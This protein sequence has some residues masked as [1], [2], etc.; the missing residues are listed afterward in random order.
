M[1]GKT[2]CKVLLRKS[3]LGW[4]LIPLTDNAVPALDRIYMAKY[5]ELEPSQRAFAYEATVK[6]AL[7]AVRVSCGYEKISVSVCGHSDSPTLHLWYK[8]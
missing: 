4:M 6:Q 5:N 2:K 1:T 7:N 8:E 3:I